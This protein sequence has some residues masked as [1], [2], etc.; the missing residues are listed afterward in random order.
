MYSVYHVDQD[1]KNNTFSKRIQC[2]SAKNGALS[3]QRPTSRVSGVEKLAYAVPFGAQK[4]ES[5][6]CKLANIGH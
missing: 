5:Q 3:E 2:G 6:M 1:A 4:S